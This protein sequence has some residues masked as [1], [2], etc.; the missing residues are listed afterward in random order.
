MSGTSA[1]DYVQ[2]FQKI[3]NSGLVPKKRINL[4]DFF[5][6]REYTEVEE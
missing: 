5:D 2:I 1:R 6:T 4:L 3:Y